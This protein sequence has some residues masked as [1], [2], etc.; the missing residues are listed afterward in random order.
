MRRKKE[1]ENPLQAEEPRKIIP[2]TE[3]GFDDRD[4]RLDEIARKTGYADWKSYEDAIL[5]AGVI[6]RIG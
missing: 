6:F 4:A 2:L 1:E 5:R 3:L